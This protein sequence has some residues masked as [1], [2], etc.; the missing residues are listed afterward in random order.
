MTALTNGHPRV[1]GVGARADVIPR[2][3]K[4]PSVNDAW[5]DAELQ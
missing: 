5:A 4:G 1:L 3:G 2:Q